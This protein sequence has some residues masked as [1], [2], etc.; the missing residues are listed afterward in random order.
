MFE[1][2]KSESS[3]WYTN[4]ELKIK[5]KKDGDN[6]WII[7]VAID[8]KD[9]ALAMIMYDFVYWCE[10]ELNLP[11]E[12]DNSLAGHKG[13]KICEDESVIVQ[14]VGRFVRLFNITASDALPSFSERQ[15]NE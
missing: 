8:N 10:N 7:W 5:L 14:E 11:I 9:I 2:R 13:F 3:V 12:T 15:W 4:G 6:G 1:E